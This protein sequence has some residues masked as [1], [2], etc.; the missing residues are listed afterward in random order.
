M[1][2]KIL[3]ANKDN[4]QRLEDF[5]HADVEKQRFLVYAHV[6]NSA[7]RVIKYET[8]EKLC[9]F[10]ETLTPKFGVKGYL[11]RVTSEGFTFDK[12]KKKLTVWYGKKL[13]KVSTNLIH[14]MM[15]DIG[16]DWYSNLSSNLQMVATR[17]LFEK[18][19]R[20]N[21]QSGA[22]Y[23]ESYVKRHLRIKGLD[24]IGYYGM[25]VGDNNQFSIGDLNAMLRYSSDPNDVVN[26]YNIY[27]LAPQ[28]EHR[29]V[30]M[31]CQILGRTFDW[32][33]SKEAQVAALLDM[34][35]AIQKTRDEYDL[36][37]EFYNYSIIPYKSEEQKKAE[38]AEL[39]F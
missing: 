36:V 14:N 5:K 30:I 6:L 17:M 29:H 8:D 13:I 15:K 4:I 37:R 24:W 23:C 1:E 9:Y 28:V 16:A 39:P 34:D 27:H 19:F 7:D 2:R 12:A 33:A 31:N 10:L 3:Y 35:R 18:I 20:G 22:G 25:V 11:Q 26:N 38:E 21:I 32:S